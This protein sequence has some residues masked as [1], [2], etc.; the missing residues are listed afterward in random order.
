MKLRARA[1]T[2]FASAATLFAMSRFAFA[3]SAHAASLPWWAWALILFVTT[4]AMGIVAVV[5][6]IGGGVLFV[7]IVGGF[8][9]FH[10][11]FVR[12]A[13]LM[14]ALCSAL[15]AGPGLLRSGLAS[16][17][18]AM[19]LALAGSV[20]GILGALV[21]LA[22][23]TQVVQ[24]ALGITIL[25]IAAL[26][27][28]TRHS[29]GGG[30]HAADRWA[31]ALGLHGRYY[32]PAAGHEVEWRARR[33]APGLVVFFGIG[34]VGGLFG[35]GAGWANVPALNLLMGIPLKLAV[36]TSG[37]AISIINTSA[38]WV[39]MNKGALLPVLIVPSILG[40]MLGARV[41]VRLLK[42][43]K[44]AAARNLII[45]VLVLSGARSLLQGLGI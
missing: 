41:G 7:P 36:G 37:L 8:F 3:G 24:F 32:D 19:P 45:G 9:P 20:G 34:I 10:L 44:A 13:G 14:I 5:G 17:R 11:D 33:T 2:P 12:G 28:G 30:S 15:A 16:L 22:L 27:W 18:L 39:Y 43:I 21:G 4:F 29:G 31:H 42:D 6:G 40:V 38:A 23:P 26:M 1:V 25:A 35:L